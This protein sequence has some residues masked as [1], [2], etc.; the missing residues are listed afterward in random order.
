MQLR[1]LMV[2]VVAVALG[3]TACGGD[4]SSSGDETPDN[5][6]EAGDDAPDETDAE[7]AEDAEGG[8]AQTNGDGVD[9][10]ALF[11]AMANALIEAGSFEFETTASAAGQ[12]GTIT[13]AMQIDSDGSFSNMRMSWEQ[14]GVET[15]MLLVDGQ[16][17]VEMTEDMGIPGGGSWLTFNAD[18][19]NPL[20]EE[21]T[22][23]F[24][25]I[26]D[27]AN[28]SA[29]LAENAEHLTVTETGSATVDGVETTEYQVVDA[30]GEVG[31]GESYTIWID[32]DDL[33]RRMSLESDGGEPVE[34]IYR[35]Y[36]A[37]AGI[38]APPEDEVVD[39]SDLMNQ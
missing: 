26:G 20:G 31:M 22:G 11:E 34:V 29:A 15:A 39:F 3:V 38:E 16:F 13:G 2:P 17:F 25:E 33:P 32:G 12:E 21:M 5:G 6:D 30:E 7:D 37:D 4:D 24:D 8:D 19:D 1:K 36:G 27:A 28:L 14:G 10:V 18:G 23:A 35:N 9:A